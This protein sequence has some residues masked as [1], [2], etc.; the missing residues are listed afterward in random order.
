MVS[1]LDSELS[2]VS[3]NLG[4]GTALCSIASCF[5][6]I[7]C[8]FTQVYKWVLVNLMLGNNPAMN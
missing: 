3:Y 5:T 7:V 2:Y 8:R 6:L 4:W 1:M